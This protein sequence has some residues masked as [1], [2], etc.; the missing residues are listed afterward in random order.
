MD[1]SRLRNRCG[2]IPAPNWGRACLAGYLSDLSSASGGHWRSRV[3]RKAWQA[4]SVVA[5]GHLSYQL[6]HDSLVDAGV[7]LCEATS[8]SSKAASVVLRDVEKVVRDGMRK[9][10]RNPRK[11]PALT[12]SG[13]P[14]VSEQLLVWESVAVSRAWTG[15]AGAAQLALLRAL[16][17][18][19]AEVGRL[20]LHESV[21]ELQTRAGHSSPAVT[22]RAWR[23][24]VMAG[25]LR[26]DHR[27]GRQ[28]RGRSSWTLLPPPELECAELTAKP[29]SAGLSEPAVSSEQ[30]AAATGWLD[31][32]HDCW[33]QQQTA[34]RV[35]VWLT[36]HASSSVGAIAAA[37]G[38]HRS[39]VRRQL[40][41]LA[42]EGLVEVV[43]VGG[44][45][46]QVYSAVTGGELAAAH[47][48][49]RWSESP[50]QVRQR[51][52]QQD[53]ELHGRWLRA[54]IEQRDLLT[55]VWLDSLA[56][57]GAP[58]APVDNPPVGA[59]VA[60]DCA[61]GSATVTRS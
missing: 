9:G 20:T 58:G 37:T 17:C 44:R 6:A 26:R 52:H 18:T 45:E 46:R 28:T 60:L 3:Y 1:D 55:E 21:R 43:E 33:H 11:A 35:A 49:E 8:S 13:L 56:V 7:R 24:L 19:A 12:A 48:A 34:W 61:H 47:S 40:D 51:R 32:A 53:R 36:D 23:A 38:L 27:A 30:T 22:G 29:V 25:W 10:Q 15:R 41:W 16:Y 14:D 5:G 57:D 2:V 50:A 31:P 42:S 4:G 59:A 39:T 54:V